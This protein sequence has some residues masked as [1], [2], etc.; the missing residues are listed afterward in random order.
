VL[1]SRCDCRHGYSTDTPT[2]HHGREKQTGSNPSQPQVSWK[3][4][5]QVTDIE[6]RD[7]GTPDGIAH[8]KVI[9]KTSKTGIGHIDTIEVA[10]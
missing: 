4:A 7:T 9:L 3:L 10:A 6:S 1:D 2:D 8:P 5:D